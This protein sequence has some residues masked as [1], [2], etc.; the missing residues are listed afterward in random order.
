L[1]QRQIIFSS[2]S[3][4]AYWSFVSHTNRVLSSLETSEEKARPQVQG[5][6]S[7][8]SA[9]ERTGVHNSQCSSSTPKTGSC[10]ISSPPPNSTK[11]DYAVDWQ[12]RKAPGGFRLGRNTRCFINVMPTV[13]IR[14]LFFK[15]L[16]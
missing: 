15:F 5:V 4:I 11:N 14:V 10:T 16:N 9:R 2:R 3:T 1:P 12:R 8:R 6:P 13:Q 7:T